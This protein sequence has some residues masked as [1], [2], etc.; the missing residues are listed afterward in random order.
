MIPDGIPRGQQGRWPYVAR[1]TAAG[2]HRAP[3]G[4]P[5]PATT[6]R[7]QTGRGSPW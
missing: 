1:P 4:P 3:C 6:A 7:R 2:D 5:L